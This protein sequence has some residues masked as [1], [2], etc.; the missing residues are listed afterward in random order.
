MLGYREIGNV[1]VV[2]IAASIIEQGGGI[3]LS[4]SW[5]TPRAV[6]L[7]VIDKR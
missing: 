2:A 1:V 7:L 3:R 6:G 5:I 4:K